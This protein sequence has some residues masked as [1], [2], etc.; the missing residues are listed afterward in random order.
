[1]PKRAVAVHVMT[2]H[3]CDQCGGRVFPF[4]QRDRRVE[5]PEEV[6]HPLLLTTYNHRHPTERLAWCFGCNAFVACK[7]LTE[8]EILDLY[9]KRR[10]VVYR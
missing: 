6:G 10:G 2:R 9:A 1:M 3:Y 4:D 5:F 8:R 7:R